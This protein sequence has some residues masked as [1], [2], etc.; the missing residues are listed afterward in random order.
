MTVFV[1]HVVKGRLILGVIRHRRNGHEGHPLD[2]TREVTPSVKLEL[3]T[4]MSRRSDCCT[5][6]VIN[7][8]WYG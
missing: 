3:D 7:L 5:I 4:T 8:V 6:V 1:A 2:E